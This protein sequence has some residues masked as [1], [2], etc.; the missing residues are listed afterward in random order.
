MI[1]WQKRKWKMGLCL[2]LALSLLGRRE[3][4][5]VK[6]PISNLH[7]QE[8]LHFHLKQWGRR[9]ENMGEDFFSADKSRIQGDLEQSMIIKDFLEKKKHIKRTM[10]LKNNFWN[11]ANENKKHHL[12]IVADR[13]VCVLFFFS[14]DQGRYCEYPPKIQTPPSQTRITKLTL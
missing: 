14:T 3:I 6:W 10:K 8:D 13:L 5:H 9:H 11:F 12:P 2:L 1:E 7:P 4:I